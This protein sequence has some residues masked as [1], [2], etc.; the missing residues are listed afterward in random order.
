LHIP[1]DLVDEVKTAMENGRRLEGLLSEAGE[2]Y[3]KALKH[4][5]EKG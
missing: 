5:K 4:K 2:R 1:K 3:F